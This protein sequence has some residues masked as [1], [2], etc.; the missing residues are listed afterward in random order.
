MPLPAFALSVLNE[1]VNPK[2]Q[3]LKELRAEM[4]AVTKGQRKAPGDAG[5]ISFESAE[6]VTRLLTPEN[7]HLLNVIDREQPQSVAQL[8]AMVNRAESNVSRTL[9]KLAEAGF[10]GKWRGQGKGAQGANSRT[11]DKNQCAQVG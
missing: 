4:I 7:R 10:V 2:I 11:H 8:A 3:S 5:Q 1:M 9:T 6:A